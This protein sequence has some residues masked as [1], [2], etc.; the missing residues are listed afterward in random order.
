MFSSA[1]LLPT[2][3]PLTLED[4]HGGINIRDK[5]RELRHPLDPG[6]QWAVRW[7]AKDISRGRHISVLLYNSSLT[8]LIVLRQ[9]GSIFERM[10][11]SS[12]S[13]AYR[14]LPGA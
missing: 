6:L 10:R 11:A 5:R 14:K 3:G 1:Q 9:F 7:G 12:L 2:S 8:K 13:A 4:T